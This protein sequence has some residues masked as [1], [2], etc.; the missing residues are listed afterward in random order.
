[1][2]DTMRNDAPAQHRNENTSKNILARVVEEIESPA[3][4]GKVHVQRPHSTKPA[5]P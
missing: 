3:G 5:A 1:M 2:S 4:T